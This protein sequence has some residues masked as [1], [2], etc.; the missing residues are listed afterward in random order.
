MSKLTSAPA[1][2]GSRNRAR[3]RSWSLARGARTA[4]RGFAT[5]RPPASAGDFISIKGVSKLFS[6]RNGAVQALDQVDLAVAHGEFVS[7]IGPS[8][9]GKSTLLMLITGLAPATTGS[10]HIGGK[11]IDA[12]T[13]DLGI[14]FQ[15]DVLLEWRTALENVVLQAQIRKQNVVEARQRA[16]QLLAMVGLEA[17]ASAYPH[18][19]SGGMRQR[20]AICRAL[21][22][23][24]PLLVMDE[25]FGALDALTRDQLNID[26]LRI[27]SERRMTVLFVTH[28]IPEAVF[29]SDRVVVMSPRPGHI[30][31]IITIDL[32]RPRRLSVR[33]SLEF[34]RYTQVVTEVFQSLGVLRDQES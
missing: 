14:V 20:V 29:L 5:V 7:I 12:P 2:S 9:C 18:E 13:S 33:Q 16:R 3:W 4:A 26:L 6:A 11:L 31:R 1:I 27:W 15:Q 32:P 10:I 30:E 22:H 34:I 19:L 23:D 17:F 25:P 21:L 28:S 8:G 24:P